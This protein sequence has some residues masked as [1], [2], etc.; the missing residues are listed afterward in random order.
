MDLTVDDF[1]K[2]DAQQ[3]EAIVSRNKEALRLARIGLSRECRVT[4][5][6]SS[7]WFSRHT[8][9]L[10]VPRR[11]AFA[12]TAEGRLAELENR[13]AEALRSY[14]D[15][16]QL[17]QAASRGGVIIDRL[18]GM[19][20]ETIGQKPLAQLLPKLA[21][22]D[23]RAALK[24]LTTIDANT[25]PAT[26]VL[27]HDRTWARRSYG[28]REQLGSMFQLKTRQQLAQSFLKKVQGEQ[29]QTR[30]LLIDIAVRAYELEKG[31]RPVTLNDLVPEYL[32]AI[33]QDPGTGS[34]LVYR[35]N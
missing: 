32:K 21:A 10:L 16:I 13:P 9:E 5:E 27:E 23:C 14:L 7:T 6:Y 22:S 19:A 8:Q 24:A 20:C 1:G 12:F 28:W 30:L 35:L 31:K 25:E 15:A 2:L 11:L 3:L 29:Q 17:G 33:P 4:A 34:N 26:L 18:V